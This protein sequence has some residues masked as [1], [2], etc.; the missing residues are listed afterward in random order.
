MHQHCRK[1]ELEQLKALPAHRHANSSS[2]PILAKLEAR[3]LYVLETLES[4][5]KERF[6]WF[7]YDTYTDQFRGY[8][9]YEK[10]KEQI[11]VYL[12]FEVEPKLK[13]S[14]YS[15]IPLRFIFEDFEQEMKDTIA[16]EILAVKKAEEHI[17]SLVESIKTKL[18]EEEMSLIRFHY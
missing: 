5:T 14:Y 6:E 9:D 12:L 7:D 2:Y 13:L 10:Y 16:K 17:Q 4:E 1:E 18:T 15:Q 8:F 3:L 11:G